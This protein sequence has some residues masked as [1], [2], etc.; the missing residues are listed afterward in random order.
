VDP[1]ELEPGEG[2]GGWR[3][4]HRAGDGT[5]L[6]AEQSL[7][8]EALTPGSA[9]REICVRAWVPT[10]RGQSDGDESPVLRGERTP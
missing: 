3:G 7:G 10:A 4:S 6:H 5:L 8:V 2:S 9:D 1:E